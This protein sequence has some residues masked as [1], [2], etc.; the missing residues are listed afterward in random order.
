MV[1]GF[2]VNTWFDL[3]MACHNIGTGG[4]IQWCWPDG[5]SVFEQPAY[6]SKIFKLILTEINKAAKQ[7]KANGKR[8]D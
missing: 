1:R 8:K 3:F 2:L 6:M 7:A 4:V 5:K